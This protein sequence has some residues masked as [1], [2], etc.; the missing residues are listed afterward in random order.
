MQSAGA[1]VAGTVSQAGCAVD[2]RQ[3]PEMLPWLQR[4]VDDDLKHRH[5]QRQLRSPLEP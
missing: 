2:A 3:R 5:E 1:L 4:R